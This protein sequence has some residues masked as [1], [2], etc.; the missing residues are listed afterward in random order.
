MSNSGDNDS[1]N[2]NNPSDAQLEPDS[3][4]ASGGSEPNSS[5]GSLGQAAKTFESKFAARRKKRLEETAASLSS[6]SSGQTPLASGAGPSAS[7]KSDEGMSD[8]IASDPAKKFLAKL[9]NKLTAESAGEEPALAGG[10]NEGGWKVEPLPEAEPGATAGRSVEKMPSDLGKLGD[11]FDF[12]LATRLGASGPTGSGGASEDASEA[13]S[14]EPSLPYSV[15]T[16]EAIS[17]SSPNTGPDAGPDIK[18]GMADSAPRAGFKPRK[19]LSSYRSLDSKSWH[20]RPEGA[21]SALT[22]PGGSADA[23]LFGGMGA[24]PENLPPDEPQTPEERKKALDAIGYKYGTDLPSDVTGSS[25]PTAPLTN[26]QFKP[27]PPKP[28]VPIPADVGWHKDEEPRAKSGAFVAKKAPVLSPT[29]VAARK[30]EDTDSRVQPAEKP[31]PYRGR[32]EEPHIP[33]NR[34]GQAPE[35]ATARSVWADQLG[36]NKPTTALRPSSTLRGRL[37]RVMSSDIFNVRELYSLRGMACLIVFLAQ[38]QLFAAHAKPAYPVNVIGAQI[39][40][41]MSGFVVTRWLLVNEG[42]TIKGTLADF[43]A[44]RALRI[45]P[46]YYLVLSVLMFTGHLP[47]PESFYCGLF[48]LKAY[49]AAKV[50]AQLLQYWTLCI[51]M[52]FYCSFP[53]LLMFT[54]PR[55]RMALVA[56]LTGIATVMTYLSAQATPHAQDWFLLPICGQYLM[57]GCLAAYM[58]VKSDVALS[59]NASL[60]VLIGIASQIAL[61]TWILVYGNVPTADVSDL[62]WKGLS[63]VNALSLSILIFGM[64]RTS[65]AWLKGLIANDVLVYFGKISYGFYLLLPLCF[66]MQPSIVA[67]MPILAKVPAIVTSFV[68]TFMMAVVTFH[69]LQVPINNVREHLPIAR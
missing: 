6:S 36:I 48:N 42:L 55:F 57:W 58:D 2:Q 64:W 53:I 23:K 62:L 54:P 24:A 8:K 15:S 33:K 4:A 5:S 65:N 61:H 14:P 49:E 35:T 9:T 40:F 44:R 13:I 1:E 66:F 69:Y 43:Y 63:T 30:R 29:D 7:G 60:C 68:I 19:D 50:P 59:V 12:G 67:V 37:K 11:E 47:I 41:V 16:P 18:P 25:A 20:G 51:E 3:N 39:F 27:P 10:G 38:A 56:I 28:A 34:W 45:F 32:E 46:M 31:K 17:S 22:G 21:P 26:D 52:Q